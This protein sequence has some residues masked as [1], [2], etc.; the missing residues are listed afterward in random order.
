MSGKVYVSVVGHN[1]RDNTTG[2]EVRKEIGEVVTN[3]NDVGIKHELRDGK[4]MLKSEWD[5]LQ[6]EKGGDE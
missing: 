2:K 1:Y 6:E 5:A 3:M 4:I